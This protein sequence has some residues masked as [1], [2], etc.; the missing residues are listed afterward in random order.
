MSFVTTMTYFVYLLK[1]TN[2]IHMRE[3]MRKYGNLQKNKYNMHRYLLQIMIITDMI[4]GFY[5]GIHD[6]TPTMRI[7][8]VRDKTIQTEQHVYNNIAINTDPIQQIKNND[9]N[10]NNN[11]DNNDDI[12]DDNNTIVS[13]YTLNSNYI[14][15][16]HKYI[17]NSDTQNEN[18]FIAK[19]KKSE[20][21]IEMEEL[22][23]QP[24]QKIRIGKKQNDTTINSSKIKISKKS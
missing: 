2:K 21:T 7:C 12:N 18:I 16:T 4:Q 9:N 5:E 20:F 6:I 8:D 23:K 1:F 13:N 14:D 15:N 11:N 19:N 22:M 10:N 24:I 17:D 3:K